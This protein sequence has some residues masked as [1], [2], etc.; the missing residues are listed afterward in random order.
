[1]SNMLHIRS[2]LQFAIRFAEHKFCAKGVTVI[3]VLFV[4]LKAQYAAIKT[5]IDAA[6]QRVVDGA[7]F[8]LGEEVA[9]FEAA[10][11]ATV[12][13]KDAVGVSSGT[14]ALL[15]A[16]LAVGA[17]PGDEVITTAHTFIATAEAVSRIGA[18][19]VFVDIDPRTY[20]LDPNLVEAA[21][22]ERTKVILPVHLYGQPAEL[23]SLREIATRHKLWLIEDAAQA[24]AAEYDGR[25]CGSIGDLACFSFYPSKNL[26]AYGDAGAVSGNDESLLAK[27]RKLR[28]HGRISKYEHDELGFGQ[29]IDAI[30]AAILAAKVPHLETWTEARRSHAQL[31]NE[32]LA[33]ADVGTPFASQNVRHVYHLYVVRTTRRDVLLQHLKDKGIEAGIHYPIPVH[34]QPVYLKLGYGDVSLPITEKA[35]TEI[36]SL[37]MY[38]ELGSEQIEYVADAVK[39]VAL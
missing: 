9:N 31:Y 14:G 13:A 7:G 39:E 22:T 36:L 28:D 11:A 6:I 24:I 20:N 25:R 3:Q 32:L 37:P 8:I 21:I 12:G 27:V 5:E 38:P 30:Q 19:P 16:L 2:S 26:G 23:K 29:R 10:L 34:R 4:D 33:T 1:M 15:L 35:A 17:E 18:R